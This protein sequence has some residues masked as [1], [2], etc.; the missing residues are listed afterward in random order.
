MSKHVSKLSTMSAATLCDSVNALAALREPLLSS[1]QPIKIVDVPRVRNFDTIL[2][3]SSVEAHGDPEYVVL[4]PAAPAAPRHVHS[5]GLGRILH[6]FA[7]QVTAASE[8]GTVVIAANA[9]A[10]AQAATRDSHDGYLVR[11]RLRMPAGH[12]RG[13]SKALESVM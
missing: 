4:M 10:Q 5:P 9:A 8:F 13:G 3:L 12:R 7:G 1:H 2:F 6:H 11:Q